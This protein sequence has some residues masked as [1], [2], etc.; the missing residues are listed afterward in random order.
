MQYKG[1]GSESMNW[2]DFVHD[3]RNAA[4]TFGLRQMLSDSCVVQQLLASREGLA[5]HSGQLL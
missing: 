3:V 5:Q 2:L 4:R 1:T